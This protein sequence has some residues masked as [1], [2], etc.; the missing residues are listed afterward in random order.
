[1]GTLTVFFDGQFWI[2]LATRMWAG[3][4][5]V[6]RVVFGHEPTEA[7]LVVWARDEYRK[8]HFAP[9][10]LEASAPLARNPKRRL[11][12]ARRT[13]EEPRTCTRAQEAWSRAR[14]ASQ[15]TLAV[16]KG[17]DRRAAADLR[18]ARRVEKRKQKHRG[19]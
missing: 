1:M 4:T 13:L 12:E 18:Y 6:A 9:A 15:A 2:G 3:G 11:R 16:E 5:E 14:E 8:V 17:A 10:D 7:E 19:R